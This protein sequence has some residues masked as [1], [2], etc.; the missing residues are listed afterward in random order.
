MVWSS[1]VDD[2]LSGGDKVDVMKGRMTL[3]Q[4]FDLDEVGE[5]QEYVGCKVEYNKEEG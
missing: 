1:W 3:K 4:Y 2:L 5:L